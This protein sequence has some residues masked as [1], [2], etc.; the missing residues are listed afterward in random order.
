MSE[1][2]L[3]IRSNT[4]IKVGL[5]TEPP[6]FGFDT[7]MS[8]LEKRYHFVRIPSILGNNSIRDRFQARFSNVFGND[9]IESL[10]KLAKIE[11]YREIQLKVADFVL[12]EMSKVELFGPT[13]F[14][15]PVAPIDYQ[16]YF[17][18]LIILRQKDE[19]DEVAFK[20]HINDEGFPP[21]VELELL[22]TQKIY[23]NEL[24]ERGIWTIKSK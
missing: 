7:E 6:D 15:L 13:V 10:K 16:N 12:E 17:D 5:I 4:K 18:K 9:D 22:K 3:K 20:N 19:F 2:L 14:H 23:F 1:A 11:N 21:D 8:I 24:M